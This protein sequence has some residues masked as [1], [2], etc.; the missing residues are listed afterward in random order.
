[1]KEIIMHS[2]DKCSLKII[3]NYFLV[4]FQNSNMAFVLDKML[5]N[6]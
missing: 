1:M 5:G 2:M 3:V 6:F 4:D